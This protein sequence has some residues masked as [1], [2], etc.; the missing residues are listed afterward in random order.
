MVYFGILNSGLSVS[1]PYIKKDDMCQIQFVTA[2]GDY[3]DSM[4]VSTW[5]AVDQPYKKILNEAD[6]R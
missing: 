4:D 6:L 3:K 1:I 2:W 5:M